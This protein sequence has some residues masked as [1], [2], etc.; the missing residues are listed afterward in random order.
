MNRK[1]F[2]IIVR[3]IINI[4]INM[5]HLG[6]HILVELYGCDRELLN[7]PAKVEQIMNDAAVK[8]GATIFSSHS[9]LF[10]PH[11]VSAVVIIAESHITIHTWP[12][13]GYAAVDVF[14]CGESVSPWVV[15]DIME[16]ELKA[17][18]TSAMEM[19]RG[20]FDHPVA[21]KTE[22]SD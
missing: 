10:N 15:K 22:K 17:E 7:D 16:K 13:H 8:S 5:H 9:N 12:E 19:R 20:L 21:Y 1:W 14:T 2:S 6:T 11:G 18:R 3:G 4:W